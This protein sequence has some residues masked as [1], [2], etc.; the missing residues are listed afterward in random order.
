MFRTAAHA[1][2]DNVALARYLKA[3]NVKVDTFSMINQDYAWG[4]DSREGL[5]GQR[6]R[7]LYPDA[8]AEARTCCRS[9]APASTAPRSRR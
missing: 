7:K 4:Q 5:H 1:A 9:S 8:K 2:M 6:W 3:R